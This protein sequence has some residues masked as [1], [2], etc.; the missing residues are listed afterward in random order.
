MSVGKFLWDGVKNSL[1]ITLEL[2]KVLVPV[3]IA[4]ALLEHS[5]LLPD[6][7]RF[8]SPLMGLVGLPGE[9]ALA[10][11]LGN[12]STMYT[13]IAVLATL[14][15]TVKELTIISTMLLL[16]HSLLAETAVVAKAGGRPAPIIVGRL[17]ASFAM[18]FLL[19]LVL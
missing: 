1:Q 11:V 10:F 14:D 6:I 12:L 4:I 7:A 19:S 16:C 3:T 13:G 18:A 17:A 2:A 5:G 8:F 15:L 9:T